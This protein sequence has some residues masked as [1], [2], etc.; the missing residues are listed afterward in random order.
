MP[1]ITT[2]FFLARMGP[3][4]FF[5]V[6]S[7]SFCYFCRFSCLVWDLGVFILIPLLPLF[8][9]GF[10]FWV[11]IV[12][13]TIF[14]SSSCFLPDPD[15]SYCFGIKFWEDTNDVNF[16]SSSSWFLSNSNFHL[17]CS[18]VSFF[19][20][21]VENRNQEGN[22]TSVLL[23]L[24]PVFSPILISTTV[25]SFG[26]HVSELPELLVLFWSKFRVPNRS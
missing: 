14:G 1:C 6:L 11:G 8:V 3:P 22:M 12:T 24:V 9:F 2:P 7:F 4:F 20:F 10:G 25:V 19:W 16:R 15:F 23:V 21:L 17:C 26:F 18:L 13:W 5:C